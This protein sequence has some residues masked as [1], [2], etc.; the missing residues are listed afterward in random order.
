MTVGFVWLQD[1]NDGWVLNVNNFFSVI[2]FQRQ[3]VLFLCSSTSFQRQSVLFH[4]K[5]SMM[6]VLFG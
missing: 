4:Y 6:F 5:I 3:S 2:R 1:L